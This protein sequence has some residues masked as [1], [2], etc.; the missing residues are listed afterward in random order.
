MY[1]ISNNPY[2]VWPSSMYMSTTRLFQA[3]SK[4]FMFVFSEMKDAYYSGI[5]SSCTNKKQSDTV[6]PVPTLNLDSHPEDANKP[7][8]ISPLREVRSAAEFPMLNGDV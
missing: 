7:I 3:W 2:M 5:K 8:I 6:I 1:R 4:L